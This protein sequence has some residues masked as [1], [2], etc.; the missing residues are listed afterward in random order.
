MDAAGDVPGHG[1]P[2]AAS[3]SPAASS[4]RGDYNRRPYSSLV[5]ALLREEK[6]TAQE[7]ARIVGHGCCQRYV[8]C[9]GTIIRVMPLLEEQVRPP[10]PRPTAEILAD[11]KQQLEKLHHGWSAQLRADR[12]KDPLC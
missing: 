11:L 4:R 8:R 9:R 2:V 1:C 6:Y 3:D 7:I 12:L 10:P 5:D